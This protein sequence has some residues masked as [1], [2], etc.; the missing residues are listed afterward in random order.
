MEKVQSWLQ[1]NLGI[2]LGVCVG[3]AVIEV[4]VPS[5]QPSP[6]PGPGD[7]PCCAHVLGQSLWPAWPEHWPALALCRLSLRLLTRP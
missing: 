3:V 6:C 4:R 1:D 2:I 7:C 5:P